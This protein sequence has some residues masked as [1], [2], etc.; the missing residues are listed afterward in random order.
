MTVSF[1]NMWKTEYL[2]GMMFTQS[3]GMFQ[4]PI[5]WSMLNRLPLYDRMVLQKCNFLG[6]GQL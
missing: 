3:I 5:H 4:F 2:V 6:F 1:M